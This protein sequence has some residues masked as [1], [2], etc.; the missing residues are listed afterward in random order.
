MYRF[1]WCMAWYESIFWVYTVAQDGMY[2][3]E[4]GI[5]LWYM[6]KVV[7]T[8]W[9]TYHTKCDIYKAIGV[10]MRYVLTSPLHGRAHCCSVLFISE[11]LS[12]WSGLD[13]NYSNLQAAMARCD[14]NYR[15]QLWHGALAGPWILT[16]DAVRVSLAVW[17]PGGL[18]SLFQVYI[19][20]CGSG[21][22]TSTEPKN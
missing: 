12:S 9:G 1:W 2:W 22:F 21:I 15:L 16:Q 20:L 3:G 5:Y 14:L 7:Y 11:S 17:L 4:G 8:I 10:A 13:Y 18:S 6:A 19:C